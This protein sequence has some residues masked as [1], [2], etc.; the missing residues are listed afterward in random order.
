MPTPGVPALVNS[1][2]VEEYAIGANGDEGIIKRL[3]G[4]GQDSAVLLGTFR[5]DPGQQ[6]K[7]ELPHA[8]GMEEEIYYLLSG[9]LQVRWVDGEL[10]AEPGDAVF[11]PAGGGYEI[12]TVGSDPVELIW[13]AY[14]AP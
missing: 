7:F 13:T 2:E 10:V 6:G 12:E 1:A 5:L 4:R 8:N 11:F 3:I 9:R 14:P